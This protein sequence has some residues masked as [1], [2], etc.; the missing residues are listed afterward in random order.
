[1]MGA[2]DG[3]GTQQTENVRQIPHH[4]PKGHTIQPPGLPGPMNQLNTTNSVR[5]GANHLLIHQQN[6]N[7]SL[8]AQGDLLNQLNPDNYDI[9]AIQEPYLDANHNSRAMHNWYMIYPKEHYITPSCTRSII[10]VNKW[11]ATNA[12][13]QVDL[14]SPDI[15]AVS[16]KTGRGRV[17]LINLYNDNEQQQGLR[18]TERFCQERVW[19]TWPSSPTEHMVMLGNFNL[20]HPLW[21]E[22]RNTHLFMRSN[23]DNSQALIDILAEYDLQ[24]AL[25]KG[26]PTLQALST[27]NFMRPDNVFISSSIVGHLV[28]CGTLPDKRPARSDHIPIITEL[29]LEVNERAEPPCPSFR[30]ADWKA[31]RETLMAKLTVL[32]PAQE[33]R[34][35]SELYEQV[36]MLTQAISE[37]M[38]VSVPKGGMLPHKKRW[39]SPILTAKRAEVHRLMHRAYKRRSDPEDPIHDKHRAVR[40]VYAV[41]IENAKRDH[42]EG[43]LESLNEKSVWVA[44]RYT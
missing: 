17:L 9:A 20:H 13:V 19:D 30:L 1:M 36:I 8:V 44:H 12:W 41:L 39:W 21:D 29:D 33:T 38:D 16:I 5:A 15:T 7:K 3:E 32:G 37:A 35:H 34:T 22:E 25:P 10:L 43:F 2:R 24:M 27:G 28:R 40:K 42:W 23:L 26:I 4:S 6:M 14:G 11:I 31:V 18:Q